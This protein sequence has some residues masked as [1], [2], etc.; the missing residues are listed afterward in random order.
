MCSPSRHSTPPR[1]SL[2]PLVPVASHANT[3][4]HH[5]QRHHTAKNNKQTQNQNPSRLEKGSREEK[6]FDVTVDTETP[7]QLQAAKSLIGGVAGVAGKSLRGESGTEVD[8]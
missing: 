1:L 3:R 6:F 2:G 8:E 7:F 5:H 4:T